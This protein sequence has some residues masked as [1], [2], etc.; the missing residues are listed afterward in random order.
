MSN[1]RS[2]SEIA[3]ARARIEQL[4]IIIEQ[5]V[6]TQDVMVPPF[7]FIDH[8]FQENKWQ[9]M[10]TCNTVYPKLVCEFYRNLKINQIYPILKTKVCGHFITVDPQLINDV[11]HIPQIAA[12]RVPYPNYVDPPSIEDLRLFLILKGLKNGMKR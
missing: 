2:K 7:D 8:I 10:Y 5:A 3:A 12:P 9:S 4:T 1:K 6:V 11:T